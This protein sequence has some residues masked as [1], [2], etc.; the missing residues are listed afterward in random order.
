MQNSL[1]LSVPALAHGPQSPLSWGPWTRQESP[2]WARFWSDQIRRGFR[3]L[4]SLFHDFVATA[5][6]QSSVIQKIAI[7]DSVDHEQYMEIVDMD[8]L[9]RSIFTSHNISNEWRM[10]CH[11]QYY[12]KYIGAYKPSWSQLLSPKLASGL[13]GYCIPYTLMA[14]LG[15][16][17]YWALSNRGNGIDS[18]VIPPLLS[19][20]CRIVTVPSSMM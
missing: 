20:S 9:I 16:R 10:L 8:F 3:I 1:R 18:Y 7:H 5:A 11:Q 13:F 12:T 19:T 2:I 17:P 14:L 6:P 4:L 15:S